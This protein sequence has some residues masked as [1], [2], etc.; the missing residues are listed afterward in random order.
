MN[1]NL[2][3]VASIPSTGKDFTLNYPDILNEEL[4]EFH[5]DCNIFDTCTVFINVLPT[6]EGCLIKGNLHGKITIPCNRCAE[7]TIQSLDSQF[8][9]LIA[10]PDDDT[11]ENSGHIFN[12]SGTMFLNLSSICWEEFVLAIPVSPL[13]KEDCKGLCNQ[14]GTNLNENQCSC[15]KESY[16]SRFAILRNLSLQKR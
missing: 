14:C 8:T 11:N 5:M 7:E 2:I 6:K 13:C 10:F 1:K 12:D 16:D 15:K 3:P 9:D 4:K